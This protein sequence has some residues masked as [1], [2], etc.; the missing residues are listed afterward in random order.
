MIE[1]ARIRE[2]IP[3]AGS[4]CLIESVVDWNDEYIE[5][6]TNNH[7]AL[8]HPLRYRDRLAA[9]HLIEYAA[10]AAAIH[11]A[12]LTER[13]GRR[14]APGMLVALR[15]CKLQCDSI[16]ALPEALCVMAR[17]RLANAEG[18]IYEFTV[19]TGAPNPST[20]ANGRLSVMLS[21]R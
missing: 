18:L 6:R 9:V 13:A 5:C 17:K 7:R 16:E 12:L 11:G 10:Q 20:L 15:D 19:T 2:L 21:K 4:M 14:A 3:H 8:D 1:Q